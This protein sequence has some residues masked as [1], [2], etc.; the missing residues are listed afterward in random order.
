VFRRAKAVGIL[1]LFVDRD[2]FQHN[3]CI[4]RSLRD[5]FDQN[6]AKAVA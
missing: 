1:N 5:D 3:L 4:Q 6:A 2:G